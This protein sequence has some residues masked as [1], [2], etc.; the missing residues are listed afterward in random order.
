MVVLN[1]DI[2]ALP[3]W[4]ACL[5][6][7]AIADED[8]GV[9]GAPPA[10][11]RRAHP[12][13]GHDP[14]PRRARSGSTTATASS[15]PHWGPAWVPGPALAVTGACM[16]ITREAIERV[17][18]FDE[19]YPM[20]YEDVDW[21]LRAWQAGLRVLYFPAAALVHHESVTRGHRGR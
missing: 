10:L 4:L 13:R 1:S 9:V 15:P 3:G 20:A 17:G 18:L 11:P 5:Q 12:V 8:I 21:C 14:Q 7:A 6:Y 19:A 16:Y 2:E